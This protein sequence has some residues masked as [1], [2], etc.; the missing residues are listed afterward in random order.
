MRYS[1]ILATFSLAALAAPLP[2]EQAREVNIEA[3]NTRKLGNGLHVS[4]REAEPKGNL[5]PWSREAAPEAEPKGNLRPWSAREAGPEAKIN[6]QLN[7]RQI[8]DKT[9]DPPVLGSQIHG[10]SWLSLRGRSSQIE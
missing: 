5:R 1:L 3:R 4:S 9:R 7:E 10:S 2:K 6:L 8:P